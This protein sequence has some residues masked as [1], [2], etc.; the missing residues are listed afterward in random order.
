MNRTNKKIKIPLH[1]EKAFY[2]KDI[3]NNDKT[4]AKHIHHMSR[5]KQA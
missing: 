2:I 4:K 3:R 5:C 1:N